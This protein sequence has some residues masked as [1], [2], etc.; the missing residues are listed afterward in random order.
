MLSLQF[1]P[2]LRGNFRTHGRNVLQDLFLASSSHDESGGDVRGGRKLQSSRPEVYSVF[3][4][5]L[6]KAR[7]LFDELRRD[8]VRI[9]AV[10]VARTSGYETRIK[11]RS[12]H[13]GDVLS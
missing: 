1:A 11:G 12:D 8:F 10:I 5:D 4:S 9:F 13:E 2:E 6:A 7:A 3:R